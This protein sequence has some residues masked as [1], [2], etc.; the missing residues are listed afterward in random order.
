ATKIDDA[1]QRISP[2]NSKELIEQQRQRNAAQIHNRIRQWK[3]TIATLQSH[4]Q[5]RIKKLVDERNKL[6][7]SQ[8]AFIA[9]QVDSGDVSLSAASTLME[10]LRTQIDTENEEMFES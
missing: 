7:H 3:S 5:E 6:F 8:T 10:E 4:E 9:E 2:P 1:I